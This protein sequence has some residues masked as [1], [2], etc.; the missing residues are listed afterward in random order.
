MR[1]HLTKVSSN[2]KTGPIAVSTTSSD[3]CP[4]SCPL[5]GHGCYAEAGKLR[6]HWRAVDGERGTDFRAFLDAVKA[7]PEDSMFRHNQA[8]DLPGDGENL[9]RDAVMALAKASAH[10]VAWTYTHYPPNDHNVAVAKEAGEAGLAISFSM[11]NAAEAFAA[12][13]FDT[14]CVLPADTKERW[15][16]ATRTLT[17]PAY[18]RKTTCKDCG[19]CAIRGRSFSVGFP[20]HGR[21][22]KNVE[23][24]TGQQSPK[25]RREQ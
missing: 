4:P 7:L 19:I 23:T 24:V 20:A 3:S 25:A 8:G 1:F 16:H 13:G 15:D 14:V 5:R 2:M 17:C 10:L 21:G 18:Y 12:K 11:D 9:D 6:F 22:A